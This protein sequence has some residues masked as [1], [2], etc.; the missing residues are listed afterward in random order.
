MLTVLYVVKPVY[1]DHPRDPKVVVVDSCGS[2]VICAT[3]NPNGAQKR[4][5]L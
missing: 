5:W 1:N 4:L 2:E 3:K